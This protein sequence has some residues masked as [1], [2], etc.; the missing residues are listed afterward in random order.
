MN[1]VDVMKPCCYVNSLCDLVMQGCYWVMNPI[2]GL[3]GFENLRQ[4]GTS[5]ALLDKGK[6]VNRLVTSGSMNA[7][8]AYLRHCLCY[9][10]DLA[11]L[12]GTTTKS[13]AQ[14]CR[15]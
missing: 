10:Q 3:E 7:I 1:P 4:Y 15:G 11:V 5:L 12:S 13:C 2:D 14:R 6:V 9:S 8:A